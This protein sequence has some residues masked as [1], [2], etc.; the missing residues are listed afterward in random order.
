M[1]KAETKIQWCDFTFNPWR[2]CT[3]VSPGCAHCYAETLSRRNP[4]VLGIWGKEGTREIAS[5]SMWKNPIAWNREAEKSGQRRSVFCMSLGDFFEGPDTMREV[6]WPMVRNARARVF[7]LIE[8]TPWLDW[9]LLT[10]RPENIAFQIFESGFD[11]PSK[12][13][14]PNIYLGTSA[15]NQEQLEKRLPHLLM[16]SP[17]SAGTFV[18]AEPL[19][20][21]LD[22]TR[23]NREGK[24]WNALTGECDTELGTIPTAK[25]SCVIAGGESGPNARPMHPDWVRSIRDQCAAAG[26]DFHFKQWGEWLPLRWQGHQTMPGDVFMFPNGDTIKIYSRGQMPTSM[27]Q[28]GI[29]LMRRVGKLRAGRTIDGQTH[30]ATPWPKGGEQ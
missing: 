2:G 15:E 14:Y 10:K 27:D 17:I 13:L 5:E 26:V 20:G 1:S 8:K 3:K 11:K 16:A 9:L 4:A 6:D 29:Q 22:F 24:N 19:L 25:I 7:D 30:D 21:P 18:S 28:P 23:V 12:R